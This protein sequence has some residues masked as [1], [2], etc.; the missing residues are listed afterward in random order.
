[1]DV[2]LWIVTGP[3][4]SGKTTFCQEALQAVRIAGWDAAGL[5]SPAIFKDGI[6]ECIYAEDIRS[7]KKRLLAS[8]RLQTQTDLV[9]G[10]WFF[11]R[12]TLK[13]G[14]QVLQSSVPCDLLIIDELGPLEF[15]LATGWMDAFDVI[16]TARYNLA[17]VVVRPELLEPANNILHPVYIIHMDGPW[18]V[19]NKIVQYTPEITRLKEYR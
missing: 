11:N 9:F 13:W 5:L 8:A 14:N 19:Q 2:N 6:K 7:G 3:S 1:M 12:K 15:N 17:L 10:D 16:H 4:E 18:D